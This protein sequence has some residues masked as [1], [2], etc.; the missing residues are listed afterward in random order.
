MNDSNHTSHK[1]SSRT[2]EA[3][4]L[5]DAILRAAGSGLRHHTMPKTREAILS[6][7]QEGLERA[8]VDLLAVANSLHAICSAQANLCSTA[9]EEERL[10]FIHAIYDLWNGPGCEAM[11]KA[12]GQA[13]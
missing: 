13:A 2:A 3:E 9:S 5:A 12:K 1:E 8:R 4:A 6:T 10:R 7:A 11:A